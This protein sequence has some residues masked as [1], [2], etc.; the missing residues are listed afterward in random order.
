LSN[1]SRS[2]AAASLIAFVF[3]H[4]G[5][6]RASISRELFQGAEPLAMGGAYV[7]IADDENA[8]FYNPAGAAS[9]DRMEVH[10][11]TLGLGIS[12]GVL[13][14]YDA[15]KDLKDPSGAELNKLMGK[16]IMT[17]GTAAATLIVPNFGV[18][19]FYD[20]QGAL[21]AA[22]QAFPKVEFGYQR[23]SGVQAAL[24]FSFKDGKKR[25]KGKKNTELMSETR[26]GIGAKYLT[27]RGG[28]KTLNASE[29]FALDY[30]QIMDLMGSKS[31][32]YGI[33][34]G[35]QRLQRLSKTAS[36]HFGA[37]ATN[38]GDV[39]FEGGPEAVK[40]NLT[41]G[42]GATYDF[43]LGKATLAY[44]VRQLNASDDWR[45]KQH[46]GLRV[47]VPL[48]DFYA[49]L[50]Q[51]YLTYGASVDIWILRVT[52]LSYREETGSFVY[53]DPER[54]YALKVDLKFDFH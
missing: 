26:F 5:E 41:L 42:L 24:G 20:A 10:Y 43:G 7:A 3:G 48:L 30:N 12:E 21:Y 29:L 40:T 46:L 45:K 32:S 16:N 25:G 23:T 2:F 11:L 36:L 14:S 27:R 18:T 47:H 1:R 49:G 9:Y 35:F 34:L 38:L 39:Q 15:V 51:A 54:R 4:A 33:D 19:A 53:Q 6:A 44:D 52:A 17:Q 31:S 22:N 37:A 28:Y 50:Y 8:I 13:D